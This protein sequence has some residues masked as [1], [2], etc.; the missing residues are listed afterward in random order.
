MRSNY[1]YI[2]V[3][4]LT[5][6]FACGYVYAHLRITYYPKISDKILYYYYVKHIDCAVMK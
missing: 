6:L 1:I 3:R 5:V 4:Y 2:I